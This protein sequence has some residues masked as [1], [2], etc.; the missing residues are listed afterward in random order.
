MP[1]AATLHGGTQPDLL[2]EVAR[3]QIDDFWQY[4]LFAAVAEIRA[5]ASRAGMPVRQACL[6][7]ARRPGRL[8]APAAAR[9]CTP[10]PS[11]QTWPTGS[12]WPRLPSDTPHPRQALTAGEPGY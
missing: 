6:D 12:P 1:T 7:L 5:A 2:G 9:C 4:A 3:W 11:T 10:R 8:L